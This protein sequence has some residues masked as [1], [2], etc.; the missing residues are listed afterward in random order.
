MC[1]LSLLFSWEWLV[2]SGSAVAWSFLSTTLPYNNHDSLVVAPFGTPNPDDMQGSAQRRV[3]RSWRRS[4]PAEPEGA[5]LQRGLR[6]NNGAE[7]FLPRRPVFSRTQM[8]L[9]WYHVYMWD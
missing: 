6:G 3:Q 2:L 9:K 5:D 4:R 8:I 7:E 1:V